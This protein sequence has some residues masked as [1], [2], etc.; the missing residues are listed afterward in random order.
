MK[1]VDAQGYSSVMIAATLISGSLISLLKKEIVKESNS[2]L[3]K[4]TTF[5]GFVRFISAGDFISS[6]N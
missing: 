6:R 5:N 4:I 3:V 2:D 1:G